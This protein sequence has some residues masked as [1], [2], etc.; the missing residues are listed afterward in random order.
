M[1]VFENGKG[2]RVPAS[3]YE[4]KSNRKKLIKIYSDASPIVGVFYEKEKE[5]YE[6]MLISSVDRAIVLKT[7]LIPAKATKTSGGVTLMTLKKG[8]KLTR[9]L[10]N[11]ESVFE[12]AKGY[13]KLK[14]PATG[15]LLAEKDIRKQQITIDS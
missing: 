3:Q 14:I 13:R 9:A 15:Q 11:F 8:Q 5:P 10:S 6:I 1:F 4:T 2:V 7:S 12:N